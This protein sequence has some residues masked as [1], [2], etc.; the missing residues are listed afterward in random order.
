MQRIFEIRYY[1]SRGAKTLIE[2]FR[3]GEFVNI[4]AP[5]IFDGILSILGSACSPCYEVVR[6]AFA[7]RRT[8]LA[9]GA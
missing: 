4:R 8:Y 7:S 5:N 6:M 1:E 3:I 2:H 9:E